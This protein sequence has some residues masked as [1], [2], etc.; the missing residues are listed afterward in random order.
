MSSV[1][2]RIGSTIQQF[3]YLKLFSRTYW[4]SVHFSDDVTDVEKTLA[5]HGAS[6]QDPSD[7]Q[8]SNF[9]LYRQTLVIDRT[10][11]KT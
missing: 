7:N 4:N 6:S 11:T 10:E 3:V 1:I 9:S 2:S 8:F 5:I